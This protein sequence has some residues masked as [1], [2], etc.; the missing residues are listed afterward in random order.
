[1]FHYGLERQ[2]SLG[3]KVERAEWIESQNLWEV[4][5]GGHGKLH[6]EIL[7]N[8]SGILNNVQ[9]PSLKHLDR[10]SGPVLHTAAWNPDV[11]LTGKSVA[12]IGAGASAIQMLP[13]IS[14]QVRHADI[15]IRTPSWIVPPAGQSLNREP[16]H[17]YTDIEKKTWTNDPQY[18][19]STRKAME[20]TFN[21]MFKV[22]W[23]DSEDQRTMRSEMECHMRDLIRDPILQQKLIPE[24]ELGCR[25]INPGDTY[26]AC[27]Q[28][29]HIEP[30]FDSIEEV[31]PNGV[32][33]GGQ[34]RQADVLIAATGFDTSFKPRFPIIS[35]GCD[36]RDLWTDEP[37]SYFGTG[38]SGFP[39]YLT[40]LGPNTP[41]SNG[42]LMGTLE[43][44]A[45]YFVRLLQKYLKE[46]VLSFDVRPGA[47]ADF[48]SHTQDLMQK[49]VWTGRCSSWYKMKSGRIAALWPGSS[50]HYRETLQSNRWEDYEWTYAHN[51]FAFWGMGLSIFEQDTD[52]Q[53][54]LAYYIKERPVLPLEAY[55]RSARGF[56]RASKPAEVFWDKV[57][58]DLEYDRV[59]EESMENK[60]DD[61]PVLVVA[62]V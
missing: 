15:Y 33:A 34:V 48:D 6:C 41:I 42:S 11:D 37:I 7:C 18:S 40:Y 32:K 17:A 3:C 13:A 55:Y 58:K 19:V 45:E 9:W 52:Q 23:K 38:V 25:R 30:I 4:T 5:V 53:H 27:L 44:T 43:A 59:S 24:F 47:Q 10:F 14:R 21:S 16:N 60:A 22:F 54:D 57:D 49:M 20:T 36:L 8:A 12:I 1:M 26:L 28:Q 56:G 29:E 46:D 31:T 61:S 50:L 62:P 2:I 35:R 51:R 39:N